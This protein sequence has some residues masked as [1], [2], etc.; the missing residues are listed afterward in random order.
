MKPTLGSDTPSYRIVRRKDVVFTRIRID[1]A[2]MTQSHMLKCND[3]PECVCR[4]ELLTIKHSMIE[5]LDLEDMRNQEY[6]MHYMSSSCNKQ[7]NVS[8]IFTVLK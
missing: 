1:I 8:V 3:S 2:Y 5:Y 6:S 4:H 7:I